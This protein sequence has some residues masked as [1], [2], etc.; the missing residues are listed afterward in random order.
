MVEITLREVVP[1]LND[2]GKEVEEYYE[3]AERDRNDSEGVGEDLTC[4]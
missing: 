2:E 4:E 1:I 3:S